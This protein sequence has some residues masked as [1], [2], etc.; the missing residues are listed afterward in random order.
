VA[1]VIY[2][3]GTTG[4][5]KG[6][7]IAHC[8]VVNYVTYLIRDNFLDCNTVGSVYA[9]FSFDASVIE[10]YPVLL[11]GGKACL[12]NDSDRLD[13]AKVNN[14]FT[15]NNV[16]YAFLPTQFAELF[17]QLKN[18]TLTNLIVGGDKL[19]KNINQSYRIVNAYGTTEA[20]VQSTS[21]IVNG[22]YENIPIGK[23]ISNVKC[24]VVD[25]A[26]NLLPIGA[27]G[28][29][30]VG[31]ESLARGYL[32]Q[33]KLTDEKFI[34]NPFQMI[35]EETHGK[36]NKVYKT[37]DLVRWLPSGNLEY[38]SRN[39]A[40]IKIRGYRIEVS[41]IENILLNYPGIKECVVLL[42]ENN[43]KYLIGYY[44]AQYA[45]NEKNIK[46][47]LMKFLPHYMIP[48]KLIFLK[49]L[50]LNA[51]GKINKKLLPH[52]LLDN[53]SQHVAPRNEQEKI[54]CEAF[55]CVLNLK[56]VGIDDNFFNIGGDSISAITLVAKLKDNFE[57]NVSD[58]FNLKTP[59]EIAKKINA[60]KDNFSRQLEKIK[61]FYQLANKAHIVNDE[62]L[63][64]K[65]SKYKH[66]V[67]DRAK[68]FHKKNISSILLTGSTGYLGCNLLNELLDKTDYRIF[69][70]IRSETSAMGFERINKK[71]EFY[72]DKKLDIFFNDRIFVFSGD[73]QK[74]NL[75]LSDVE[76]EM[77]VQQ[78]DSIIHAAALTKHYGEY[79]KFYSANVQ[80]TIYL[81][82]LCKLTNAK[83]FHYISTHSVLASYQDPIN[84]NK[85]SVFTEED[86]IDDVSNY[87]NVYVK[88]KAEGEKQV[89]CY[90]KQGINANIYRVGNLAFI[91]ENTRVQEN[92][93]DN[94]FC[95]RLACLAHLKIATK[96]I[97]L[98]EISPVDLTARALV[99]LFDKA[100][101][102]NSIYH[103]FNPN[104]FDVTEFLYAQDQMMKI[105]PVDEF[106]DQI[107]PYRCHP[108]YR[109]LVERFLLHQGWLEEKIIFPK[110]IQ[111]FQEKTSV[112]LQS[113]GFTWEAIP[114]KLFKTFFENN[115]LTIER[116][117]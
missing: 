50:P 62:Q 114:Q 103:V 4:Q 1:Y 81:L 107:I 87:S 24:Y 15:R 96:E 17:F 70:L 77:L 113:L 19:K 94:A 90:Q 102:C 55:A 6:T 43:K 60:V 93:E 64:E 42:Q 95:N 98:E 38:I 5:P 30:L 39:D 84:Y 47:Y 52:Y 41:E 48:D 46:N 112:I 26:L 69:L 7:L 31:G 44:V 99:K 86:F 16:T 8:S 10:V 80:A 78:V 105:L 63:D 83:D 28:E 82:E 79:E 11:S 108:S 85:Y 72:F 35:Q 88:T 117:S 65:I 2:T 40:Q 32:N 58:I 18:T 57:V 76:Y 97:G 22:L 34:H 109:K 9:P 75:G 115:V 92:I 33:S 68:Y 53:I 101:L 54:I 56:L 106:I 89:V 67:V 21:F 116:M 23:P 111:I 51:N 61:L 45:L 66:A 49:D 73:I 37:G 29:L 59:K 36:N 3:S 104:F 91:A 27:V 100:E 25:H 14:Y 12:I 20:T 74:S 71:F 110:N 13:V